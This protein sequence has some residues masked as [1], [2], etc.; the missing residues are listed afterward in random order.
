MASNSCPSAAH[1][2]YKV[3]I[4]NK[5]AYNWVNTHYVLNTSYESSYLILT[6]ISIRWVIYELASISDVYSFTGKIG[7]KK[8]LGTFYYRFNDNNSKV[9]I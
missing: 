6:T 9:V 3:I 8:K 2:F 7:G 4:N 5:N 1:S